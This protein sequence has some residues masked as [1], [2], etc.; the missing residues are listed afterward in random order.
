M[1]V[2]SMPYSIGQIKH[3]AHES[4]LEH[5]VQD[6]A[7][8]HTAFLPFQSHVLPAESKGVHWNVAMSQKE[9]VLQSPAAASRQVKCRYTVSV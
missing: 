6:I 2:L 7:H 5:G 4:K 9:V 8:L 1:L 3:W